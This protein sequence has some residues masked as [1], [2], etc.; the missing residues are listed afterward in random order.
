MAESC[1]LKAD[2]ESLT[3]DHRPL[4][5]TP[6][7]HTKST[8]PKAPPQDWTAID[9]EPAV[10]QGGV[11]AAEVGVGPLPRGFNVVQRRMLADQAAA[12]FAAGDE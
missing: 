8:W 5:N 10:E 3:T 11:D 1:L 2:R 9:A 7:S 6:A 4:T 12:H